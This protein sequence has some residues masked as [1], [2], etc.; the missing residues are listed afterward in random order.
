MT[1]FPSDAHPHQV[2]TP[3]RGSVPGRGRAETKSV[4]V[5]VVGAGYW[6]PN[7]VRNLSTHEACDLRWVCDISKERALRAVGRYST[8]RATESLEMVLDDPAVEAV[9]VATPPATHTAVALRC[10][11]AGKHVLIEKPLA[12]SVAEGELLVARAA[13]S[14]L[15][16]MLDHTYCYTPVVRKL[17]DLVLDGTLGE[18]HYVDS[19]RINLGIVQPDADVF[20]DL[21]PHDLSILDFVLG[22]SRV[23]TAVAAHGA[24]PLSTGRSCIGYLTLPLTGNAIAHVHINWLSPTK[25]RT[26]VIGGSRRTAVWDDLHPAQ[27]LSVYDRGVERIEPNGDTALRQALTVSYRVGDMVAPALPESEALQG[28]VKEFISSI[29]EGRQPLTDG[30]AGVRVLRILEAAGRSLQ[31]HGAA[32]PLEPS[33]ALDAARLVAV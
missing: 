27:R 23:P 6:G 8:I 2:P 26:T 17:R 9:A 29:R 5:A 32:V 18:I 16:L 15:V 31:A 21:A 12:R 13:H 28:V 33:P 7:L 11:D 22:G 25:I 3:L 10:L 4:G 30:A 20:W 1:D 24:D 19:V 14:S